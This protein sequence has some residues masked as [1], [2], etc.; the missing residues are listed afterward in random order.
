MFPFSA[1]STGL[2]CTSLQ[3]MPADFT[4]K[5]RLKQVQCMLDIL[6]EEG[7]LCH[8]SIC[9]SPQ[10]LSF[11]NPTFVVSPCH[12][13]CRTIWNNVGKE[14]W[15]CSPGSFF[16][17]AIFMGPHCQTKCVSRDILRPVMFESDLQGK[18]STCMCPK[19]LSY[20]F[21]HKCLLSTYC[22]PG[23]VLSSGETLSEAGMIPPTGELHARTGIHRL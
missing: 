14:A 1:H 13:F 8:V 2:D 10:V 7:L 3:G 11:S 4:R 16:L 6:S 20:L 23:T 17:T 9:W 5:P 22:V 15:Q 19:G 18:N 21:I 12:L